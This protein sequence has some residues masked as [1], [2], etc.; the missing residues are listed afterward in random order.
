[1]NVISGTKIVST[2]LENDVA[3]VPPAGETL[4]GRCAHAHRPCQDTGCRVITPGAPVPPSVPKEFVV[5][6]GNGWG[7]SLHDLANGLAEWELWAEAAVEIMLTWLT[8][9]EVE[10]KGFD[11][12]LEQLRLLRGAL[13]TAGIEAVG[14]VRPNNPDW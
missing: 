5:R 1:M 4:R 8:F 6:L 12:L 10:L 11:D 3:P 9:V 14:T 7:A 13:V 2:C